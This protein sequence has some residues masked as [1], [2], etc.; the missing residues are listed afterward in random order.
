M[1]LCSRMRKQR[2]SK[3]IADS[4]MQRKNTMMKETAS[5]SQAAQDPA[6]STDPDE[7]PQQEEHP[8][9]SPKETPLPACAQVPPLGRLRTPIWKDPRRSNASADFYP[10][11]R[12]RYTFGRA[13][14][15]EFRKMGSRADRQCR[16]YVGITI[17]SPQKSSRTRRRGPRFPNIK[18]GKGR[19]KALLNST[20]PQTSRTHREEFGKCASFGEL[21]LH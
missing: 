1:N 5:P 20:M 2:I 10:D 11:G 13:C 17:P 14:V 6:P 21:H 12:L 18:I 4:T 3:R 16:A 8:P 9:S 19:S 7:T 15:T